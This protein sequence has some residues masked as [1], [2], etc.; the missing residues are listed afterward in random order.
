MRKG[1]SIRFYGLL[2]A[3]GGAIQILTSL[4]WVSIPNVSTGEMVFYLGQA[5]GE[6]GYL[7][8]CRRLVRDYGIFKA[9]CEFLISVVFVD[10]ISIIILNPNEISLPKFSGFAV[11][12]IILLLRFNHYGNSTGNTK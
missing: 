11:A 10:I 9:I 2:V 4:I 5:V 12:F 1:L 7:V 6:L 8:A 3:I